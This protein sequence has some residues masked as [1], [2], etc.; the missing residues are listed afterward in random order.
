MLASCHALAPRCRAEILPCLPLLPPPHSAFAS[1]CLLRA[2]VGQDFLCQVEKCLESGKKRSQTCCCVTPGL[3]R[4]PGLRVLDAQHGAPISRA[5]CQGSR[6]QL[7][8]QPVAFG[9]LFFLV[10][11]HLLPI[12][13]GQPCS[14]CGEPA[15]ELS[16]LRSS[17]PA[18]DPPKRPVVSTPHRAPPA[19]SRQPGQ[20]PCPAPHHLPWL[21]PL[22][23]SRTRGPG[24]E[25]WPPASLALRGAG[26]GWDSRRLCRRNYKGAD[27]PTDASIAA[28]R[29]CVS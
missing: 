24:A 15:G 10:R 20:H 2:K 12:R 17:T 27:F 18:S 1:L 21:P 8:G 19:R 16:I 9:K 26:R 29:K 5:G 25:A 13:A 11:S 4:T 22:P 23:P 7:P 6:A 14:E 28:L 3:S